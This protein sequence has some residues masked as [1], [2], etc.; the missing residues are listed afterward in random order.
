MA[1]HP[2]GTILVGAVYTADPSDRWAE[3]VAVRDG[4]IVA[5]GSRREVAQHA[6]PDTRRLDLSTGMILPGFQDAHVHPDGGGLVKSRCELHGISGREGYERAVRRYADDHP[7]VGWILGGG[8]SLPDFPGGTPHRSVLD[9]LVPDRPVFLKNRDGHGAWVNSRALALAGITPQTPDPSD[10]RIERDVD[11]TPSGTLHEGAMGLVAQLV[12]A[13]TRAE[14]ERALLLAQAY[15]HSLGVTGW[16]DAHVTAETL[17][18]YR[19]LAERGDLTARVVASLWWERDRGEEQVERL[20]ELRE[21]GAADSLQ[22]TSV[23]IMQDGI[24]ENFTAAMIDLYLDGSRNP[25]N[26]RGLSFIDP[27]KLKRYVTR[28]DAEGFQVHVHAIGDRA[29]REALDAF[30]AARDANGLRDS[31]HHIAHIQVV[32]P[33]DVPRFAELGVVANAQPLWACLDDQMRDLTVPFLG[34]ER[35]GWQYPFASLRRAGATLAFGSDWPV[36]T[37]NPLK[38]L[39]VAVTRIPEDDPEREPFLQDERLELDAAIDAF[40]RRSAFVNHLDDQAGT[41]QVGKLADLVVLDRNLFEI[42][43]LEIGDA[44]VL[45]TMVEGEPVHVAP[46]VGW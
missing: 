45:L 17:S 10:G 44:K 6:G 27:E 14:L 30:Q 15:L 8:W 13:P 40:T 7:A 38:E 36:T 33:D 12:P 22:A 25:S 3:S 28:L 26:R 29:V 21:L 20:L 9:A 42:D 1:D 39:Q 43:A 18:A 34:P 24:V 2:A 37:P 4:R 5:V 32:H 11:G 41:V 46:G 19:S 31:R 35:V 23:K 16:Q